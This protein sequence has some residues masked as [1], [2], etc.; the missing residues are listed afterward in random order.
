[1][2]MSQLERSDLEKSEGDEQNDVVRCRLLDEYVEALRQSPD[3]D[4]GQWLSAGHVPDLAVVDDLD[5][6]RQLHDLNRS[7]RH[8]DRPMMSGTATTSRATG[9]TNASRTEPVEGA[10]PAL[11]D[12]PRQIGKY[13]VDGL[14]GAGGQGQVF[15]VIDNK[16]GRNLVLKVSQR[17]IDGDPAA[18][19]RLLREGRLLTECVHPNLI[20]VVD[21]D[22]HEGRPFLVMEHI[23]GLNL[24]QFA[25]DHKPKPRQAA[26][27]VA[28]VA[29]A[30]RYIHTRG[31]IHLDIK[32]QNI[33]I[34][35]KGQPRLIDFGLAR[36]RHAWAEDASRAVGGTVSYMSPEQASGHSAQ[37]GPWTDVFGLGGVFYFLLTGRPVYQSTT[38]YGVHWQASN[39][40][41]LAPRLVNP[42]VP[43][44]LERICLKA[45]ASEPDQR[46]RSTA[47][48]E[49]ALRRFL[50]RRWVVAATTAGAV[51]LAVAIMCVRFGRLPSHAS[52][53][54]VA[55]AV[56]KS[57]VAAPHVRSFEIKH[58]RGNPAT[59]LGTIGLSSPPPFFNDDVR[60]TASLDSP[61]YCYLI[62]FNPDGQFQLCYPQSNN[63]PPIPAQ[64][65]GYPSG[66]KRYFGLTDGLGLQAF[67]LVASRGPLP[68][69]AR[70]QGQAELRWRSVVPHGDLNAAWHYDGR[71]IERLS[72]VRRGEREKPSD[73]PPAFEELCRSFNAI[74]GIDAIEAIAFFV[75]EPTK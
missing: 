4:P 3:Q 39:G 37:I 73:A 53:A 70:W 33:L 8:G 16:L 36:I 23:H 2:S 18:Y 75:L 62:A 57:H 25:R 14:L 55:T 66:M 1:M 29:A 11:T 21:F 22:L 67:V 5:V 15:R 50:A 63:D 28:I 48:F 20:R 72:S 9:A 71:W 30:V 27:I 13:W 58:F 31:I 65:I 47:E 68:R 51:L 64:K 56:E 46:Y 32:P 52:S 24:E 43:R 38:E 60:V 19:E 7:L 42:N 35:R 34:D 61:A 45:L 44:T 26:Q 41:Q 40:Q 12:A 17:S 74:P 59:E 10:I 69:F 49:R 54:P 6:I